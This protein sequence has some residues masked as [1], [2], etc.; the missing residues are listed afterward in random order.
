MT[1]E[2][3]SSTEPKQAQAD[4]T[5][6]Q[7]D[8]QLAKSLSLS[9]RRLPTISIPGLTVLKC[10]GEGA[11]GSVW[12]AREKNTGKLV[13]VKVYLHRGGLDWSLLSREVEKLAV[14][15]TSRNIVGLLDVGW[16][17]DPPYY[18]MEYLERGS[19]AGLLASGP[20]SVREAVRIAKGILQALVHAHGSGILHCDL[21]PANVLLDSDLEPRLCD[22][23]QSRLS[24]E[25]AP[26]LG[27][28]YYMAP[29]QA[30]LKAVPDARWDVYAFGAVLH[31]LLC[32]EPPHRSI[33]SERRIEQSRSLEERLAAYRDIV[34]RGVQPMQHS[35]VRG[36]DRRL[37]ELV[38]RCLE[39]DPNKRFPN[40]QAVLDALDQRERVKSFRPLLALGGLGPVLLMLALGL[41]YL[42]SMRDAVNSAADNVTT[43]ALESDVLSVEILA[44]SVAREL[45]KRTADLEDA[46]ADPEV[47]E[48]IETAVS[49]KWSDR[50]ELRLALSH[51]KSKADQLQQK[52][53]LHRD[54]SWFLTDS[55]GFQRWREPAEDSTLDVNWSHRDYFHGLGEFQKDNVPKGIKPLT[56]PHLSL[57]YTSAATG[58]SVASLAV[59]IWDEKHE[60]VLGVLARSMELGQLLSTF[61]PS[62]RKDGEPD[63]NIIR[64]VA[65][66][67][68]RNWQLLDHPWLKQDHAESS[69][70]GD[71]ADKL[72]LA[73][74]TIDRL[75]PP[76]VSPDQADEP[77]VV[78]MDDYLD[79]AGQL[80][81]KTFGGEWLA[82]FCRVGNTGWIAIVQER[83]SAALRPVGAMA[84]RLRRDGAWAL[85]VSGVLIGTLWLVVLRGLRERNERK[86][87]LD[88]EA[89]SDVAE[90]EAKR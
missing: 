72:K 68:G 39:P 66:V 10:L 23:G 58:R 69:A 17:S 31:H 29:E 83:K 28:L 78:Q 3:L 50:N 2:P 16:D 75:R 60:R 71:D 37:A 4:Q 73:E 59:P 61:A 26:A 20:L 34:R 67:D 48:A 30:D 53:G 11:Y 79:P 18:V 43:R 74:A 90:E 70:S 57:A 49:R 21:K 82:A 44:R 52:L 89:V 77:I 15:Y 13:A 14:L 8:S 51:W 65:V 36:V 63:D 64:A 76:F 7:D 19:L 38:D 87:P 85:A 12:L 62:N 35:R 84:S 22:F 27:T 80:D 25:H 81:P 1:T 86:F 55:D 42:D 32:G 54:N 33:E 88:E 9:R 47:Q 46:A 56:K 24:Y 5:E 45:E 41:F 6:R 40:A